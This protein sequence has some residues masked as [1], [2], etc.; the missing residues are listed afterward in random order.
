M[1]I[2]I[3]G[4]SHGGMESLTTAQKLYPDAEIMVIEHDDLGHKMGWTPTQKQQQLAKLAQSNVMI[5]DAT[6]MIKLIPNQHQ[7]QLRNLNTNQV[8]TAN[9]DKLILSPGAKA[10]QLPI[11]GIDN[12][13]V[14]SLRSKADMNSMRQQSQNAAIQNVVVIGAG[15]IGMSAIEP[16]VR[17]GK[18][19]TMIDVND[20]VLSNYLDQEFTT[21]LE[22]KMID[23]GVGLAL[24]EKVNEIKVDANQQLTDV[25]TDQGAYPAD[26]VI[27]SI[28]T[29]P[30]TDWLADTLKLTDRGI[31]ETDEYQCTSATDV[32]AIGDATDVFYT[33]ANQKMNIAL[34]GNARRQAR[35]A[36][37]NLI[38]IKAPLRGVQGT[39]ALP[40]FDV[41]FA[42]TGLS[43]VTAER[44]KIKTAAVTVSQPVTMLEK[45][46][47]VELK[48]RYRL[49]NHQVVG[50]QVMSSSDQTEI[51]NLLSIV[52]NQQL[53]IEAL[54]DEDFFFQPA[55]SMAN[56]IMT[57]AAEQAI[58]QT[59]K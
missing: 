48:L 11:P 25:V 51:A 52:I 31:I 29:R 23:N 7:V 5:K 33:P 34:A 58:L 15:Y 47:T 4:A 1:K 42:T 55:L 57:V 20:R 54:V 50:A 10:V 12:S 28:G 8:T 44:L 13:A 9:Y 37:R 38:T 59:Q 49:D 22:A 14:M 53:T 21:Q 39:S 30:N 6:D 19:V 17:G 36:V 32:F 41:K 35:N 56:Y 3:L 18:H 24:G 43:Q 45:A 26:L 27:L 2:L 46:P 40:F 16:F